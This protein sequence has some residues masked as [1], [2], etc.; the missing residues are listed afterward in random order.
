MVLGQSRD[1]LS[2]PGYLVF[3]D[4]GIYV[5]PMVLGQSWDVLSIPGYLVFKGAGI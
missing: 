2:I 1:V 5:V 4:P 3:K